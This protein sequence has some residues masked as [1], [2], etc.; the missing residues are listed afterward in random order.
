MTDAIHGRFVW[1][2]LMTTDPTAAKAF[3]PP[4][5]GWSTKAY[6]SPDMAYTLWMRGETGIGGLMALSDDA[7]K[8]GAPPH[9]M[10]YV[11][12]DDIA[13]TT[14]RAMGLGAKTIVP[15]TEIPTVG[16]FAVLA[17]PQ[18]AAFALLQP[19]SQERT[20][21]AP[22]ALGD[23]SWHELATTDYKAAFAFYKTLFGWEE[24]GQHDMGPLGIYFMFGRGGRTLGAL[25]NK[26]A[27]MP[28][29]PHWLLY[30]RVADA[31]KA[32]TSVKALGGQVLNGPM[33]VPG[34]DWIAQCAD[35]QGAMFAVHQ[36]KA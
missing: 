19:I 3:Y 11:G 7:R 35:P 33:E 6:P 32:A 15:P 16:S 9:W 13:A 28:G 29:P 1:Y 30:A 2:E 12:T 18:G 25:F 26:P 10:A 27:Q 5:I 4:V 8:M 21:D 23:F 31:H 17:D 34:G 14:A 36:T 24:T 22:P 20:P